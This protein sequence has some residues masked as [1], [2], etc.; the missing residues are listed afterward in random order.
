MK[1]KSITL[2]LS[3]FI[4][5]IS[6]G[7][8]SFTGDIVTYVVDYNPATMKKYEYK[9]DKDYIVEDNY[10]NYHLPVTEEKT[11][12]FKVSEQASTL[13]AIPENHKTLNEVSAFGIDN[14]FIYRVNKKATRIIVK[15]PTA[16]GTILKEVD[17]MMSRTLNDHSMVYFAAPFMSI[18]YD[19][20]IVHNP[21]EVLR[22]DDIMDEE[23]YVARY[24]QYGKDHV[25]GIRKDIFL[26]MYNDACYK[27]PYGVTTVRSPQGKPNPYLETTHSVSGSK[28]YRSCQHPVHSEYLKGIGLYKEYYQEG[29]KIYSSELAA[30]DDIPIEK[31]LDL[32]A[33]NYKYQNFNDNHSLSNSMMDDGV[34]MKGKEDKPQEYE[35]TVPQKVSNN[36]P[37]RGIQPVHNANFGSTNTPKGGGIKSNR[38]STTIKYA[39]NKMV[40]IKPS[41]DMENYHV[42]LKG[43]T[44]YSLSKRYN[45][46]VEN[47]KSLNQLADNTIYTNQKLVI[48]AN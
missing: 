22:A 13:N 15:I 47:L 5:N 28:L 6:I 3:V 7:Q 31:Y 23:R 18:I 40:N 24:L 30:I 45:T 14:D 26:K 10:I 2:F 11:L 44:L 36:I 48:K 41:T 34:V 33:P 21:G 4:L 32:I 1:T 42:V 8:I 9:T 38:V 39:P 16:S 19:Y 43:E 37:G 35:A 25:K 27:R 17:Y 29:D 12:I 46:S 20:D